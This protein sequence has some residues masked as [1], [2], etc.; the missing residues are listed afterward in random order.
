MVNLLIYIFL[1]LI[2]FIVNLFGTRKIGKI[3]VLFFLI[4]SLVSGFRYGVGTDF[5]NYANY[6][7]LINLGVTVNVELGFI[8]LSKLVLFFEFN[9]QALFLLLSS[10]TMIF[11]YKG[12]VYYTKEDYSFKPVLYII[13]VFY[14]FIPSLNVILQ[15]FATSIIFYASKYI[16]EKRFFRFCIWVLFASLFHSSSYI[17]IILYFIVS[18]RYKI[19]TLLSILMASIVMSYFNIYTL[20]LEFI[21]IYLPFLDIAG[22]ISSYLISDYNS[23]EINFGT[24]NYINTLVLVLFILLKNKLF[25]NDKTNISFNLFYL[26]I[27]SSIIQLDA[28]IFSR[29]TYYFSIYMAISV[30][31]F[32]VLFDNKT[33]VILEYLVMILYL[34][35][36]LYNIVIV[37][38]SHDIIP[39]DYNLK[40]K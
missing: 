12:L 22:Y 32:G 25:N 13:F 23:R 36:Y 5:F 35:L 11:F 39:Y 16:V 2:I 6:F 7:D 24:V 29:L 28:P 20:I 8:L 1:L 40:I 30:S 14:T 9:S 21:L 38:G 33:K 34:I 37:G 15:L 31:R 10:M 19:S 17:F 27:I 4:L 18:K 3:D 26:F